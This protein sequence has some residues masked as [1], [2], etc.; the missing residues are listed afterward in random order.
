MSSTLSDFFRS[1][2]RIT[3][4]DKIDCSFPTSIV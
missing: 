4:Q 1:E 3:Q 2:K